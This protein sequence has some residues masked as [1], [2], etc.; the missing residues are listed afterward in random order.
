M[1]FRGKT[2]LKRLPKNLSEAS[3]VYGSKFCLGFLIEAVFPKE[4]ENWI[5]EGMIA[6]EG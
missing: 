1:T 3:K 4:F 2:I 6:A 5:L